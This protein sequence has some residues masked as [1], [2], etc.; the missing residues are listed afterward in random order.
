MG[1]F[2]NRPKDFE[3]LIT[4][5][6][7][8]ERRLAKLESQNFDLKQRRVVNAADAVDKQDYITL[9][10]VSNLIAGL[11]AA[12]AE[13]NLVTPQVL[14]FA[15]NTAT[16]S[17]PSATLTNLTFNANIVDAKNIHSTTINPT[18][19]TCKEAGYYLIYAQ[20]VPPIGSSGSYFLL[21]DLINGATVLNTGVDYR[22]PSAAVYPCLRTLNIR[23]LKIN[24]Y[25][26]FLTYHDAVGA[27]IYTAN[28]S[29]GGIFRLA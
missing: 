29:I 9:N 28:L 16:Q 2:V 19:F 25:V 1:V 5:I 6:T 4:Y 8:L 23:Y 26:E 22:A 20:C 18:R 14:S 12:I 21:R 7:Q 10:Q 11:N 13:A 17:I 27:V 15:Y 24:D 3:G